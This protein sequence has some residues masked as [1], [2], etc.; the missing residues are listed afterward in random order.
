MNFFSTKT[1]CIT[2]AA[3]IIAAAGLISR[4]LGV[5]RDRV[6]AGAFGAGDVLDAYYA[7]FQVPDF[8]FNLLILGALSAGFIPIFVSLMK[9]EDP[10]KYNDNAEAWKFTNNVMNIFGGALLVMGA[11]FFV[12]APY[13]LEK[14]LPG[15]GPEKLAM[16]VEFSRIMF[17]SPFFLGLSAIIGGALQSFRRFL[18]FSLAP[19]MYN[20]GIIFG[21]LVLVDYFG[22]VGLAY[23]VVIGALLHLLVQLPELFLLG[24]RYDLDAKVRDYNF[25]RMIKLTGPRILTMATNQINLL[26]IAGL[27]STLAAGSFAI[28][29]FANNLQS[30]PLGLFGISF[31]M[32]AFPALSAAF[33]KGD[34][35]EYEAVFTSTFNK[36]TFFILP[37]SVLLIILSR[38]LVNVVLSTG[39]FQS[40]SAEMTATALAIF[41]ISL[42][43]QSL[44][45]LISRAFFAR[46]DTM[47]PFIISISTVVINVLLSF[48][49]I[50]RFGV[51]GLA[52]G[53]S[54]SAILNFKVLF[55]VLKLKQKDL[56]LGKIVLTAVKIAVA[57]IFL[58]AA[59]CIVVYLANNLMPMNDILLCIIT[60]IAGSAVYLLVAWILKIEEL[61]VF[62]SAIRRRLGKV[63]IEE[64]NSK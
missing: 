34:K 55:V 48:F 60:A 39:K 18:F 33:A 16:T 3:A 64:I 1:Q 54:A 23:G 59:A 63:R 25:F 20:L 9:N 13:L 5:V 53:F 62:S 31:A 40:G 41:S 17:L 14:I 57:T 22:P 26:F 29:N 46:R 37:F 42:V 6:L 15:F 51:V 27:A 21:A 28:F 36:I 61:N 8:I 11:V 12:I 52:A 44:S 10:K 47:A 49:L 43:A 2:T 24:W 38:P 50:K 56:K 7:A 19:A 35:K 45:P 32:A 4:L 58:A 30:L